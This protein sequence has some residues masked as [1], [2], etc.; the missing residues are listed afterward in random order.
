M[1]ILTEIAHDKWPQTAWK[2]FDDD[3][4]AAAG[5]DPRVQLR[6]DPRAHYYF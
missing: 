4:L 5:L 2:R 3:Q 1:G 6:P